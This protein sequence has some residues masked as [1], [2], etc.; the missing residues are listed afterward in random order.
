MARG[1]RAPSRSGLP[2]APLYGP[3]IRAAKAHDDA[4]GY[5]GEYPFTRGVQATMY[6]GRHWTMRQYAGFASARATN[7]RFRYLLEQGQTGLSVAFDLPTQIGYD[8]DDPRAEGEV[9]KVGVPVNSLLDMEVLLEGIPLDQ[10]SLSMTINSTAMVLLLM[11]VAVAKKQGVPIENLRG[12]VQNDMLKEFVARNTY[13]FP[14]DAHLRLVT[15]LLRYATT[16]VPRVNPISVSGYHMRE[17]GCTAVQEVAFTLANGI[18]YLDRAVEAG[19][20]V[21]TV[22][23][24]VSF[25]FAAHNQLFEE[26]AKFRAARRLWAR[27]VRERFGAKDPRSTALRFHTQTAG[28]TL[29]SQQPETNVVRVTL[30]ALAAVLGGTQSLHTNSFDEALGL[31]TQ[32]SALLALRTQ[33]VIAHESG[34]SDVVD[35]LGGD[36]LVEELTDAIEKEAADYLAQIDEM[37]GAVEAVRSGWMTREIEAAAYRAQ[38]EI[39]SGEQVVVGV[40]RHVVEDE[41]HADVLTVDASQADEV[42]AEL[43]RLREERNE[44]RAQAAL[45]A[46]EIS[47]AWGDA[48]L[49]ELVLTCVEAYC[50]IGE[51]CRTLEAVLGRG[52][53]S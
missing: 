19:L 5:P 6:R 8:S 52:E 17:A 10:V 24:R 43:A 46:L 11:V 13:R 44:R 12:T 20:D 29:T 18:A 37:G 39:E 33:Q 25:F 36:P 22:A 31:P 47:T 30:Q 1:R 3:S 38:Q 26:V 53:E 23:R 16:S 40:N 2:L 7:E 42:V 4:V 41:E 48:E 9:G 21:D 15:D 34:V 45:A 51:I 27:I 32:K 49:P 50:T 28:S 35:P 14:L